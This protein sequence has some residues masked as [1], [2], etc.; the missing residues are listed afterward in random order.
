[1]YQDLV[2][3]A[4]PR[5]VPQKGSFEPGYK[6]ITVDL[7]NKMLSSLP[8]LQVE[9]I[10]LFAYKPIIMYTHVFSISSELCWPCEYCSIFY[11]PL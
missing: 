4:F 10:F 5:E 1:M 8:L 6:I 3:Y 9:S 11:W 7:E 2:E